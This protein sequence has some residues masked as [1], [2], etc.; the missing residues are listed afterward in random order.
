[1]YPP[2]SG[3]P[4]TIIELSS[5]C[6]ATTGESIIAFTCNKQIAGSACSVDLVERNTLQ[7]VWSGGVG[8]NSN[9]E[10]FEIR[11]KANGQYYISA[12]NG[13]ASKI[14]ATFTVDCAP[15]GPAPCTIQVVITGYDSPTSVGGY[16]QV[17][18][19]IS[20]A[21]D[22]QQ[23]AAI[24]TVPGGVLVNGMSPYG[25][26][27][28]SAPVPPVGIG[29]L[30]QLT[31]NEQGGIGFGDIKIGCFAYANFTIPAYAPPALPPDSTEWFAVGGLLP[32][33]ARLT[34]LVSS[35]TKLATD[36]AN[37]TGPQLNV[38]RTGLHIELE[39][40]RLGV[41]TKFARVRKTVRS[42]TELVDVARYLRTE[43]AARYQYAPRSIARDGDG[44]LAF[45]YRYR[46]VDSDG[47]G[48]W[49]DKP[50]TRYAVLAALPNA[51][52]PMLAHVGDPVTPGTPQA[53]FASLTHWIGYPLELAILLPGDRA[54]DLFLEHRYFDVAGNEIAIACW[55][56]PAGPTGGVVRFPH[57]DYCLACAHKVESALVDADR[58]YTGSCGGVVPIPAPTTGGFLLVGPGR[59]KLGR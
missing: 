40:Y 58:S 30:C 32:N 29:V 4:P 55:T 12:D 52:D 8:S 38:A 34:C 35:L 43:L 28:Y 21:V 42:T 17:R 33:P 57:I 45:T 20:G 37:P 24:F 10:A 11:G 41:A 48:Q 3:Y 51:L 59:L 49:I 53:A 18:Y 19:R 44:S 6:D 50:A 25:N 7:T 13:E 16:G 36:P 54:V 1:M 15:V 23:S 5:T 39:L 47:P 14:S 22:N 26:G 2:G 9:A 56:V 27:D 31:V 46:E